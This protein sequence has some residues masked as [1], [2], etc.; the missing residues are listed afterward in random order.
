MTKALFAGREGV[1]FL[2]LVAKLKSQFVTI[3][4]NSF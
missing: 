2:V 3:S 4:E 1:R